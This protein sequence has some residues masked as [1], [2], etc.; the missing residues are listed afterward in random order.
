MRTEA[1]IKFLRNYKKEME[2]IIACLKIERLPWQISQPVLI[3]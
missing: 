3:R 2:R 1:V